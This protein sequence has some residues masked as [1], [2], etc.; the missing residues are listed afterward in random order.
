MRAFAYFIP[1]S[2]PFP[3]LQYFLASSGIVANDVRFMAHDCTFA[4]VESDSYVENN[5][6]D[7]GIEPS[8]VY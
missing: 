5:C 1:Y 3:Y 4:F 7:L 2:G 8:A 6:R